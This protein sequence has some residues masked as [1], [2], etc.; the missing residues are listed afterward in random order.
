MSSEE[1]MSTATLLTTCVGTLAIIRPVFDEIKIAIQALE[2]TMA[3]V[4]QIKE[5]AE[6]IF[7]KGVKEAEMHAEQILDDTNRV[8]ELKESF[9]KTI[10]TYVK[11]FEEERL[12]LGD[13]AKEP[14]RS[15]NTGVARRPA[16]RRRTV[17]E[18]VAQR[19]RTG[20]PCAPG[21]SPRHMRVEADARSQSKRIMKT[22]GGSDSTS[23]G[24]RDKK[25]R[26]VDRA[27]T[28][29]RQLVD[30]GPTENDYAG[31]VSVGGTF[32]DAN[33]V[34]PYHT[35][36]SIEDVDTS[37][38][39]T[40]GAEDSHTHK[41]T[42]DEEKKVEDQIAYRSLKEYL[43][44]FI[45]Y[46]EMKADLDKKV[47]D[48]RANPAKG[49]DDWQ[50]LLH[51]NM[52]ET[53]DNLYF[54][55]YK[56]R[57]M[58]TRTVQLVSADHFDRWGSVQAV[59]DTVDVK[60]GAW[61]CTVMQYYY[62]D[63]NGPVETTRWRYE[64]HHKLNVKTKNLSKGYYSF[65][66]KARRSSDTTDKDL[67]DWSES[68]LLTKS[69][70]AFLYGPFSWD[71]TEDNEFRVS[72]ETWKEALPII[73]A[74]NTNDGSLFWQGFSDKLLLRA[75]ADPAHIA[76]CKKAKQEIPDCPTLPVLFSEMER[77]KIRE[78]GRVWRSIEEK[79]KTSPFVW[80]DP[81]PSEKG[82]P[83]K[84]DPKVGAWM[85]QLTGKERKEKVSQFLDRKAGG[86]GKKR[87]N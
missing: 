69:G 1:W 52:D 16:G 85:K 2:M 24:H 20:P 5:R 51:A 74:Q 45:G 23:H 25:H 43:D 22:V 68:V 82:R 49:T 61:H 3:E 79:R 9:Q 50:V 73:L 56:L 7:N 39:S 59:R 4:E 10:I 33:S 60:K 62:G 76:D 15:S 58:K 65:D 31:D 87:K 77:G 75:N 71:R 8:N 11:N 80:A 34:V 48:L 53:S 36:I 14:D 12:G 27:T 70:G 18:P 72:D 64:V 63:E 42:S 37:L 17:V 55:C 84:Q 35:S 57:G 83:K 13:K 38:S 6:G 46:Q 66:D 47:L 19:T 78:T 54:V 40:T 41:Q 29:P 26:P 21:K 86:K 44:R 28:E 67:G 30:M 32:P 81:V